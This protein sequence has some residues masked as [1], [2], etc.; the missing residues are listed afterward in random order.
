MSNE[1]AR[2]VAADF[3]H[4]QP[5]QLTCVFQLA[6]TQSQKGR[7]LSSDYARCLAL[8]CLTPGRYCLWRLIGVIR[9]LLTGCAEH[10][11]SAPS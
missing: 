9:A 6:I 5:T 7:L 4:Q 2:T 11:D 1:Q 8:F 3:A 10:I